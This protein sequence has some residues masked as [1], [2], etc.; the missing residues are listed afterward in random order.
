ML[1]WMGHNAVAVLDGGIQA[2]MSAGGTLQ[3]GEPEPLP[4]AASLR[5]VSAQADTAAVIG[6]A[7][8]EQRL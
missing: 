8:I 2:W 5:H 3:S 7:E 4:A 1:R 6:T